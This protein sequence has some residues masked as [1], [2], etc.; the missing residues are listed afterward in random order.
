MMG[1]VFN[2]LQEVVTQG[3]GEDVWDELIDAA[4]V[5][6][7]YTSVG[8][9]SDGEMTALVGATSEMLGLPP[10]AVLRWFG[11]QAMPLL[12][13][14]YP[15]FFQGHASARSF[16]L[17]VNDI[18]HVE[19][20]KLYAGTQCPYFPFSEQPDGSLR[21]DYRS[22][23]RLCA[24]AQGF[25]EGAGSYYGENIEFQHAQCIDKGDAACVFHIR[26]PQLAVA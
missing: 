17:S 24:L 5:D 14:R 26:W 4:G 21:M 6:G 13:Q 7:V 25:T 1:I 2:L 9:Y 3:H 10:A 23:R 19:V 18:I 16:I 12:A 22:P 15:G 11:Q 8:S 20:R